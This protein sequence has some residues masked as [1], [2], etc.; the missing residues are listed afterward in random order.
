M[1][2]SLSN[3][4]LSGAG[5]VLT[6]DLN[7][8]TANYALLSGLAQPAACAAVVKADAYGLGTAPVARALSRAGCDR[9]FVALPAEATVLR[10]AVEDARIFVLGGFVPGSEDCFRETGAVPVL[11][12]LD[13][14]AAWATFCSA[15][16][17]RLPAVLHL[18]TGMNRLGLDAISLERVAADPDL[19]ASFETLLIMTHLACSDTPDHALNAVQLERFKKSAARLPAAP[20]SAANSAGIFNG[21][22]YHFDLVRPGIALYGGNPIPANTNPLTPVIGL[23]AGILQVRDVGS[24]DSVGYGAAVTYDRPARIAILAAGYADGL[25]RN[26]GTGGPAPGYGAR[27]GDHIAPVVGRVSMDLIAVDV[28]GIPDH[29]ARRGELADLIWKD[30]GI[31]E[32]GCHAGTIGYEILTRLGTRYH[33]VYLDGETG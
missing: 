4:A 5:G 33:R 8:I 19:L 10:A 18:D 24:G 27:I 1:T 14:I 17:K 26:L 21:A 9:F 30:F 13:E 25:F 16:K 7:A 31:D 12:S 3:S 32:M 28:T 6:I 23:K 29:L 11:G 2:G 15:E 20:L 22:D